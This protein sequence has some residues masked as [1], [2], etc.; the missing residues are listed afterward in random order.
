MNRLAGFAQGCITMNG[1]NRDNAF[2]HMSENM[3]QII[4]TLM[5]H[6]SSCENIT[7]NMVENSISQLVI[8]QT[9]DKLNKITLEL[10]TVS[11]KI[12]ERERNKQQHRATID[13][14]KIH[15][16]PNTLSYVP[17]YTN[18]PIKPKKKIILSNNI[19]SNRSSTTEW[20]TIL[21]NPLYLTVTRNQSGEI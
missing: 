5:E 17:K 7:T 8:N 1:V 21:C 4:L 10:Q 3:S 6:N 11:N 20:I 2:K 12:I 18:I 19:N 9:A 13:S 16:A 14:S 15:E